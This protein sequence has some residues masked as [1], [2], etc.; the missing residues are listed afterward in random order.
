MK[1]ELEREKLVFRPAQ[2]IESDGALIVRRGAIEIRVSGPEA[3]ECIRKVVHGAANGG[4]TEAELLELFEPADRPSVEHLVLGLLRRRLLVPVSQLGASNDDGT[5]RETSADIFYWHFGLTEESATGKL[6]GGRRVAIVGVNCISRQLVTTLAACGFESIEVLDDPLFRN[7]RLFDSDGSLQRTEW[8]SSLA[9][10]V[11]QFGPVDSLDPESF[12]LLIATSDFGG[13]SLFSRW[14]EY[15]HL[16][17]RNFLPVSVQRMGGYVGPLTVP[18]ETACFD[19]FRVRQGMHVAD[20]ASHRAVDE[21]AQEGKDVTGFL[22]PMTAVLADVAAMEVVKFYVLGPPVWRFSSVI[23][24]DL[25][26]PAMTCHRVLKLPLC[27]VCTPV[28][29][30]PAFAPGLVTAGSSA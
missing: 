19:C 21:A 3:I 5:F 30:R 7:P 11:E 2:F 17:K 28:A 20:P 16:H 9:A 10:P 25:L 29:E 24:V 14:N 18:G 8:P 26:V 13:L 1:L 23:E 27:P 6:S 15:C 12:D 22:P 4:A